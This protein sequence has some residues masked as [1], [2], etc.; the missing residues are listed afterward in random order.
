MKT[1]IEMIFNF[2]DYSSCGFN[3]VEDLIAKWY[4]SKNVI[5]YDQEIPSLSYETDVKQLL[6]EGDRICCAFGSFLVVKWQQ[7]D[8]DDDSQEITVSEE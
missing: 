4:P 3:S 5:T 8:I 7:Y 6:R 2:G 1:K